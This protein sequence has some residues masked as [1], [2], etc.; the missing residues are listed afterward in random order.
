MCN[1]PGS[2]YQLGKLECGIQ[3][4]TVTADGNIK[5]KVWP[6]AGAIA[7]E[8]QN[9]HSWRWLDTC[10]FMLYIIKIK[11]KT[12]TVYISLTGLCGFGSR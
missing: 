3:F 1:L 5:L 12:S 6:D 9:R 4:N 8:P 7:N 2:P 11:H 10:F